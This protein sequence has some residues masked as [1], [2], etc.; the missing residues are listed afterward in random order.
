M[1]NFVG[2]FHDE[3]GAHGA[4]AAADNNEIKKPR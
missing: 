1:T 4:A 3:G 2:G